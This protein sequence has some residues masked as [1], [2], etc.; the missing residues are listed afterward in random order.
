MPR[1]ARYYYDWTGNYGWRY[2][3]WIQPANDAEI[4]FDADL[5]VPDFEADPDVGSVYVRLPDMCIVSTGLEGEAGYPDQLPIGFPSAPSLKFTI[6]LQV[7][8][9]FSFDDLITYLLEPI[10]P[11]EGLV[12]VGDALYHVVDVANVMCLLSDYGNGTNP[13]N[14]MFQ[15]VQNVTAASTIDLRYADSE[16]LMDVTCTDIIRHC[17]ETVTPQI[18][19]RR[20]FW[21]EGDGGFPTNDDRTTGIC[22]EYLYASGSVVYARTRQRLKD[23]VTVGD[24]SSALEYS[25]VYDKARLWNINQLMNALRGA[26]TDVYRSLLRP[27]SSQSTP[28]DFQT[29][30]TTVDTYQNASPIAPLTMYKQ[31][32]TT[33]NGQG[34][35]VGTAVSHSDEIYFLGAIWNSYETDP[36]THDDYESIMTGGFLSEAD[37]NGLFRFPTAYD[38]LRAWSLSCY[39]RVQISHSEWSWIVSFLPVWDVAIS[40]TP[41][42]RALLGKDGQGVDVKIEVSGGAVTQGSYLLPSATGED[43]SSATYRIRGIRPDDEY[44]FEGVFSNHPTIGDSANRFTLSLD[45]SSD[46]YVPDIN[47]GSYSLVGI[48]STG[49]ICTTLYYLDSASSF[50][51]AEVPVRIHSRIEVPGVFAARSYAVSGTLPTISMPSNYYD[52]IDDPDGFWWNR[53]RARIIQE[54][55]GSALPF[56]VARSV[57]DDFG[58]TRQAKYP[59]TFDAPKGLIDTVGTR[60]QFTEDDEVTEV[61]GSVF[62]NPGQTWLTLPGDPFLTRTTFSIS[63]GV[64][65]VQLLA[66]FS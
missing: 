49:F 54:Q 60:F 22:Y 43:V 41:L 29:L 1:Q 65:K 50:L 24:D 17:L 32:T 4:P 45:D 5:G 8:A 34:A 58:G 59:L 42:T 48:G 55:S 6:D 20:L 23:D 12:Q 64:S 33:A 2:R 16:A 14:V 9:D 62:L 36:V 35:E 18:W 27:H 56:T 47:S 11:E 52:F 25:G 31:G 53:M 37:P 57:V 66:P 40:K 26:V 7:L 51:T 39:N 30:A 3:F 10:I 21:E 19:A 61:D 38:C 46:A 63:S 28:I 15:G 13:T 44:G